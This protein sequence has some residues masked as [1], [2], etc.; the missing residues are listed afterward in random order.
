MPEAS[1]HSHYEAYRQGSWVILFILLGSFLLSGVFQ[2]ALSAAPSPTET[3]TRMKPVSEESD[4]SHTDSDAPA[5]SVNDSWG[6]GDDGSDWDWSAVETDD[7]PADN[8]LRSGD[9]PITA[10]EPAKPRA[11]STAEPDFEGV[12][13]TGYSLFDGVPA[14]EVVPSKKD[15]DMHPCSD[16]HEWTESNLT[17]RSLKDPHDNFQ[18]V[19]GIHGKGEFWCF[20][21]HHLEGD[22]GLHTTDGLKL[23]FDEAYILCS[24][25]HSQEA[26]DWSFGAHG[27]RVGNW[28]GP[29]RIY[30]CTACH[31]QHSPALEPRDPMPAAGVLRMGMDFPPPPATQESVKPLR[32]WDRRALR[33]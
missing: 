3:D 19:H 21:C 23:D 2:L 33:H 26:R 15:Q 7:V 22:G 9:T 27:K 12:I 30:N 32:P 4:D 5:E 11:G 31:Y 29:R 1:E 14:F 18:L 24:Q 28:N 16:C 17:P 10:V 6:L 8:D 13:R 25:C 20:T